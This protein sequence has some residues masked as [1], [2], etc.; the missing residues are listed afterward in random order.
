M[1][2]IHEVSS[3]RDGESFIS[4]GPAIV[5][6]QTRPRVAKNGKQYCTVFLKNGG[7]EINMLLWEDAST[8]KLPLNKEVTL[9][10]KFV[11]NSFNGGI[12]IKCDELIQPQDASKFDASEVDKPAAKRTVKEAIDNGLRAVDY[13]ER[14]GKPEL[15]AQA[16][17]LASQAYLQGHDMT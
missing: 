7:S 10:G 12:S 8:W 5:T 9:R 16:F 13:I 15:A 17:A 14:R 4:V 1:A 6:N 3:M 11:R 2:T